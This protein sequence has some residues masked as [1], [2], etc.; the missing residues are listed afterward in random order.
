MN[1][2]KAK[3]Y[4]VHVLAEQTWRK[5]FTGQLLLALK[6]QDGITTRVNTGQVRVS[7][8]PVSFT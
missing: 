2:S 5:Y 1:D 4:T 3:F 8:L 7:H 6:L